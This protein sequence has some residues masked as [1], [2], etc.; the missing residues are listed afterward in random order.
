MIFSDIRARVLKRLDEDPTAPVSYTAAD[1]G[2]AINEGLQFFGLLTLCVERTV[3]FPIVAGTGL[4]HM[5]LTYG[6]WLVPLR[7]AQAGVKVR[8][9]RLGD[10]GARD[11]SWRLASGAVS[12]YSHLG[13]DLL[14]LYKRPTGGTLSIVYAAC[15]ALLALDADVPEIPAEY[16]PLL[17]LYGIYRLRFDTGGQDFA[18]GLPLFKEFLAGA[19]KMAGFVR[20]RS[21]GLRYDKLPFELEQYDVSRLVS[22]RKDLLPGR[23]EA[24]SWQS[25]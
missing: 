7:I 24:P 4:Y 22:I 5:L 21:L 16:H 17:V 14:A 23:K 10:L 9:A 19:A 25:T 20:T 8:P 11:L 6:D 1:A 15:P 12:R 13:S 2:N 18:A 3:A